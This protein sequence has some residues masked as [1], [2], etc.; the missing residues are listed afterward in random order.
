MYFGYFKI[1]EGR[2]HKKIPLN[3][4]LS[5]IENLRENLEIVLKLKYFFLNK[6]KLKAL[7]EDFTNLLLKENEVL[8]ALL[9]GKCIAPNHWEKLHENQE[10]FPIYHKSHDVVQMHP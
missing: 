3:S 7:F 6:K 5:L 9:R 2:S 1:V 4:Q 8:F 10:S